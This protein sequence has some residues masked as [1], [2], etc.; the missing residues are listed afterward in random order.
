MIYF[1][2]NP[3]KFRQ[4]IQDHNDAANAHARAA[5]EHKQSKATAT[6]ALDDLITKQAEL[7]QK[8]QQLAD[9]DNGQ[10]VLYHE[11]TQHQLKLND[12]ETELEKRA[13]AV[14][15]GEQALA[16]D[17]AEFSKRLAEVEN[18]EIKVKQ[19]ELAVLRREQRVQ[20]WQHELS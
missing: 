18:R 4:M 7:A 11:M 20:S 13:E 2:E 6:A 14:T 16:H 10:A 15:R 5:E 9:K 1:A 3:A 17:R 12:L 19:Q 8:E